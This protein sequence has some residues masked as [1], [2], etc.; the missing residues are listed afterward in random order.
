MLALSSYAS[1]HSDMERV[2]FT[3]LIVYGIIVLARWFH[4]ATFSPITGLFLL[5]AVFASALVFLT[6]KK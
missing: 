4:P 6:A 3:A 5:L 1:A 2:L